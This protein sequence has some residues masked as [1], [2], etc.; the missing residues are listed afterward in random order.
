MVIV[1]RWLLIQAMTIIGIGMMAMDGGLTSKGQHRL[2]EHGTG[3]QFLNAKMLWG[4]L[5][6]FK[7]TQ[8]VMDIQNL[9]DTIAIAQQNNV[10]QETMH[11]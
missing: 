1:W 4:A 8:K 10:F 3:T 5:T 2:M 11:N 6:M 9:W 7:I